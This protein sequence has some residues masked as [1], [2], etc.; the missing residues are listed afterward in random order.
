MLGGGQLE[1]GESELLVMSSGVGGG[2]W[3]PWA[4]SAQHKWWEL[5]GDIQGAANIR[6][7]VFLTTKTCFFSSSP[8]A[9]CPPPPLVFF[10][11][12]EFSNAWKANKLPCKGAQELEMQDFGFTSCDKWFAGWPGPSA[13]FWCVCPI[14]LVGIA[15]SL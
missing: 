7:C 3:L 12:P 9:L 8:S 10:L 15:I 5:P 13:F 1:E 11:S 4:V 2:K 6:Y 14:L